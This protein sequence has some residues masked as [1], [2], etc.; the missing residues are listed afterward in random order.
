MATLL[1]CAD[2]LSHVVAPLLTTAEAAA[3]L[4]ICERQL[5]GLVADGAIPIVNV[6]R[7]GKRKTIRFS[8][9]HLDDFIS[10][11]VT[12][13]QKSEASTS[14]RAPALG[15][16]TSKSEVID[17]AARRASRAAAKRKNGSPASRRRGGGNSKK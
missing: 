3:R 8:I 10:H 2:E 16:M 15:P 11:R 6:G 9:Q 17:F 14:A 12:I 5:R 4:G 13:C 7:D 1:D